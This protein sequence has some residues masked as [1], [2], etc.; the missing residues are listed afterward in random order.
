MTLV[1][2]VE[3]KVFFFNA[4]NATI[5]KQPEQAAEEAVN[6]V[7]WRLHNAEVHKFN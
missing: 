5:L 1:R 3:V 6:G 7:E 4:V 2:S